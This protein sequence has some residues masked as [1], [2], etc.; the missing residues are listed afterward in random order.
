MKLSGMMQILLVKRSQFHNF[1]KSAKMKVLG[2][3]CRLRTSPNRKFLSQVNALFIL[4]AQDR[5]NHKDHNHTV[6]L[7]QTTTDNRALQLMWNVMV[8]VQKSK[9]L[10]KFVV[11]HIYLRTKSSHRQSR[12]VTKNKEKS[13]FLLNVPTDLT[14][15]KPKF[16][17]R[18]LPKKSTTRMNSEQ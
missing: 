4:K 8:N 9:L 3:Y 11:K 12:A 15:L 13:L 18:P 5:Q 7:R 2:F 16:V 6:H 1:I 10:R 14:D 17:E